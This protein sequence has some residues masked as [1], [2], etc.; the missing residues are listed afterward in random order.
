MKTTK[1]DVKEEDFEENVQEGTDGHLGN[2][3]NELV[4]KVHEGKNKV[5]VNNA[6]KHLQQLPLPGGTK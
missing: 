6:Q 4:T 2:L 3:Q 5:P 1:I